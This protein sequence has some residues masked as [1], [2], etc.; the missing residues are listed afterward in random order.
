VGANDVELVLRNLPSLPLRYAAQDAAARRIAA[1]AQAQPQVV[2]V[3]HPA[4]PDS[5]AMPTGRRCAA[6]R[7]AC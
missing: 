4:L 6:P 2:R 5:P 3:L 1:W 7:P